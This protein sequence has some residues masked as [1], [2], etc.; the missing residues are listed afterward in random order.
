MRPARHL[1][2]NADDF[3]QT[4][5]INEGIIH[6]HEHGIVTSASLMVR[7]PQAAAAAEYAR[8]R[9][10]FSIGLHIDL[11]EWMFQN[12]EWASVYSVV[13]MD[14]E[15]AVCEEVTR[16]VEAFRALMKADP[17]HIDSHQHVH[18]DAIVDRVVRDVGAT[19]RVPVRGTQPV[20]YV[21]SFYGQTPTGEAVPGALSIERLIDLVRAIPDGVSELGCHPGVGCDSR[22]M[23]V[24]ERA[25]EMRALCDP[26]V[27]RVIEEEG[28]ELISFHQ[29][30]EAS[31]IPP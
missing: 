28:I 24:A 30:N 15:S 22:G 7:W 9:T 12:G 18:G 10:A 16:Q 26:R 4:V 13:P 11:G 31:R 6:C 1:I 14:D 25:E 21:G 8:A 29:L 23:Y 19:L 20:T 5:G 2:V 17:T 27:R 3:G